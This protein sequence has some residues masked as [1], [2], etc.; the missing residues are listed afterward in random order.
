MMSAH[1]GKEEQSG[2]PILKESFSSHQRSQALIGCCQN[3]KVRSI[4]KAISAVT[5]L[6]LKIR[7]L[8]AGKGVGVRSMPTGI[9][10]KE[11]NVTRPETP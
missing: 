7:R 8:A 5:C 2:L 6:V 4:N 3:S 10:A 11:S 9:W 1:Q